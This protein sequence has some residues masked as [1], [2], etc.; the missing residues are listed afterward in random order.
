MI[1]HLLA[2]AAVGAFAIGANAQ[3]VKD[4]DNF[5]DGITQQVDFG[6]HFMTFPNTP[7]QGIYTFKSLTSETTLDDI[8]AN[9][10]L[11]GGTPVGDYWQSAI[12]NPTSGPRYLRTWKFSADTELEPD[13]TWLAVDLKT[14]FN[15]TSAQFFFQE[16][17]GLVASTDNMCYIGAD[18]PEFQPI[19]FDLSLGT[20]N[21][22][23]K[24][25][26]YGWFVFQQY[27]NY[28][29]EMVVQSKNLRYLTTAEAAA[30][31]AAYQGPVYLSFGGLNPDCARQLDENG[32]EFFV[33]DATNPIGHFGS[34]KRTV[35][36]TNTQ[37]VFEY[38]SEKELNQVHVWYDPASSLAFAPASVGN[39]FEKTC[40]DILADDAE[41]K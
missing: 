40:D 7:E 38:A 13:Q 2:A 20:T 24:S 19:Y 36:A 23:G 28:P 8:M 22:W 1:K 27:Q 4:L 17:T 21:N 30:E 35:P 15:F 34:M 11:F 6:G 9:L 10:Q 5:R 32:T 18:A 31:C 37:L 16:G 25:G 41:W 3:Q 33:L 26:N 29:A 39:K 14:N 12:D